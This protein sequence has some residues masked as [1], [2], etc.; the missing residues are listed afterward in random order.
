M[1]WEISSLIFR[2]RDGRTNCQ[3][4][5]WARLAFR[6]DQATVL[7][8]ENDFAMRSLSG[9]RWRGWRIERYSIRSLAMA[10]AVC[11]GLAV[12]LTLDGPGLTIDEPLDVRP[13][14]T[15]LEV[16]RARGW[17]FFDPAVVDRVFRDNAEHPPLGRWLLGIASVLGEPFEVLWKG[18]DP[19]GQYVLA[20]RL[21]PALAFA[22]LVGLIASKAAGDGDESR[23]CPLGSHC[24]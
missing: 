15:Y 9:P 1:A 11:A 21:A 7:Q 2:H 8:Q 22:T 23:V 24:W 6:E 18:P 12:V 4:I 10:M 20:G 3:R 16:L 17:H 5:S 13:G 19:T 14:R